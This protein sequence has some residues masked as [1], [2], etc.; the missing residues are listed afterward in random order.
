M[1]LTPVI[2]KLINNLKCR[3]FE[4]INMPFI[5]RRDFDINEKEKE[6]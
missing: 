3:T 5:I 4:N 6:K 2:N 1:I